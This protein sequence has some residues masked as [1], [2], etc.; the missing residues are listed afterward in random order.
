MHRVWWVQARDIVIGF[1][2]GY[3]KE[4]GEELEYLEAAG[5]GMGIYPGS[6]DR[7]RE[8][9][10]RMGPWE[11]REIR[12]EMPIPAAP[13]WSLGSALTITAGSVH[14]GYEEMLERYYI[15]KEKQEKL[16]CREKCKVRF[17]RRYLRPL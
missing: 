6:C 7:S 2:N 3:E 14:G 15:E 17:L 8:H 16:L 12:K 13:S 4:P 11:S 1:L 10:F 9:G 5:E